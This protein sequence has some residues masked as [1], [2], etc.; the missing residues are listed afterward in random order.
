LIL[1]G[2]GERAFCTGADLKE[3]AAMDEAARWA[4]NRALF[5]CANQLASLPMP[6][7]AAINGFAL[8]GGCELMLA[9]DLRIAAA[10]AAFALP[11][12]N[13]GIIPGAGGTQRLPRL[14]GPSRAKELIFT[15]RRIDAA[16]ALAWGLVGQVVPAET[17]LTA[18]QA[19]ASEI[20]RQSQLALAYAKAAIDAGLDTSLDEGLH[21]ET[22]AFRALLAA[23]DYQRRLEAFATKSSSQF[24]PL[25]GKD[26]I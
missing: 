4:H 25:S 21:H 17:L 24:P 5:D 3:R 11:E 19:L 13:L 9:C 23:P 20:A 7:I 6:T 14:I 2:A 1:T 15:A 18:A 10:Q 8:G 22:D 16:T 26:T 12:T